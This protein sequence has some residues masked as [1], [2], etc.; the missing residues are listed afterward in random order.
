MPL[1]ITSGSKIIQRYPSEA[2]EEEPR[3]GLWFSVCGPFGMPTFSTVAAVP[4]PLVVL[5]PSPL[6]QA[7]T[8]AAASRPARASATVRRARIVPPVNLYGGCA[9]LAD[10]PP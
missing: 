9:P 4:L 1:I 8:V 7:A 3:N 2:P 6:L 10:G 5:L